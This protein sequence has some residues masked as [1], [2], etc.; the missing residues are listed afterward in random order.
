MLTM[1]EQLRRPAARPGRVP[2]RSPENVGLFLHVLRGAAL[3]GA[4]VAALATSGPL[5][6]ADALAA[7]PTGRASIESMKLSSGHGRSDFSQR[8]WMGVI[9]VPGGAR[10]LVGKGDPVFREADPFAVGVIQ[11][12]TPVSLTIRLY[13][14][15]QDAR[16]FPGRP[17]PGAPDIAVVDV[18][19]VHGID[20]RSRLIPIG[21]ERLLGGEWYF[22]GV[23]AGRAILQRDLDSSLLAVQAQQQLDTIPVVQVEPRTWE[24]SASDAQA[25]MESG[26][27]IMNNAVRSGQLGIGLGE[28]LAVDV[29]T[30]LADVRIDKRGFVITTPNLAGRVGLQVGDRILAVNDRP[31]GGFGDLVGAYYQFKAMSSI[32]TVQVT[33]ERNEVPIT[34]TYRIR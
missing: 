33:I 30:P 7:D 27:A 14:D 31:I 29:K 11:S 4:L 25:A 15:G 9:S 34:L 26:E 1:A 21:A 20:Y 10:I 6:R 24:V 28:G 17:I 12:V 22:I 18:I 19:P 13:R 32:R 16:A 3:I 5:G 8:V 2:P 23:E